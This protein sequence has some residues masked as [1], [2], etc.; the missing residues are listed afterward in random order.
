MF[1]DNKT[2]IV[3]SCM[4]APQD[5]GQNELKS[6]VKLQ[7]WMPLNTEKTFE[8]ADI[9]EVYRHHCHPSLSPPSSNTE[10]RLC[11]GGVQSVGV[12]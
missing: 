10:S 11:A 12:S 9:D 7:G 1:L 6:G 2:S 5:R 4:K 3:T 8:L